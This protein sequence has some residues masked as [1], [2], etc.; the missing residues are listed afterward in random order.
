MEE[1]FRSG[2]RANSC[3]QSVALTL[4]ERQFR[5]TFMGLVESIKNKKTAAAVLQMVYWL[6]F[7]GGFWKT[8]LR[9]FDWLALSTMPQRIRTAGSG[10]VQGPQAALRPAALWP[11]TLFIIL[12][13]ATRRL[14]GHRTSQ[15]APHTD[16]KQTHNQQKKGK[17][18]GAWY[19]APMKTL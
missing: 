14:G 16:L 11:W 15:K 13:N 12:L 6:R 3:I 8:A 1:H 4:K 17:K 18:F 9:F 19:W 7:L 10:L 5:R 2:V